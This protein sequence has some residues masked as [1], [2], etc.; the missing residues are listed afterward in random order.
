[1]ARARFVSGRRARLALALA[2]A[3]CAGAATVTGCVVNLGQ[4]AT[5]AAAGTGV[6][7]SAGAASGA[8][9][10]SG[11]G[12]A[13]GAGAG[14]ASDRFAGKASNL[15]SNATGLVSN[16]GAGLIGN[17]AAGFNGSVRGPLALIANG[18][19]LLDP[20]KGVFTDPGAGAF[21]TD[22]GAGVFFTDPGVGA[23]FTD[24]GVGAFFTEPGGAGQFAAQ[25]LGTL[26]PEP[27][28]LQ[29]LDQDY[30]RG[31][32]V[33]LTAP[34]ETLYR[35]G[36]HVIGT[37]TDAKGEYDLA[38]AR[39]AD[40]LPV[41]VNA[42]FGGNRRLVGFTVSRKGPNRVELDVGSTYALELLRSEAR[43]DGK[44]FGNFDLGRLPDLVDRARGA[45]AAG[46]LGVDLDRLVIGRQ[47]QLAGD[48]ATVLASRRTDLQAWNDLLGRQLA[49]M[50]TLAGTF[51]YGLNGPDPAPATAAPTFGASAVALAGTSAFIADQFS[52]QIAEVDA[53]GSLR[54][55][56]ARMQTDPTVAKPPPVP[57]S[58]ALTADVLV[59]SPIGL[60]ADEA[61]NLFV[62]MFSAVGAPRNQVLMICREPSPKF[63]LSGLEAGRIY[64]IAGSPEARSDLA[65]FNG[66][67]GLAIDDAGNLFVADMKNDRVVRVERDAGTLSVVAGKGP[68][69]LRSLSDAEKAAN[70]AHLFAP[71]AVAWRRT[72]EGEELFVVDTFFGRIRKV[73]ASGGNWVAAR[74]STLAGSGTAVSAKDSP[75]VPGGF[76]GDGGPALSARF[77]FAQV[78]TYD[79][80]GSEIPLGGLAVDP[81]RG[82]L[83]VA[84]T[85]NGRIR[86]IDLGSG[87][88]STLAGGGQN[89]R[90]G[91]ARDCRLA[92]PAGLAV[93][94]VGDLL[95]ADPGASVVRRVALPD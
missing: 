66:P 30:L 55:V 53:S 44:T 76:A 67:S 81:V 71:A 89:P 91:L 29:A 18:S 54:L 7:G 87:L 70:Q 38:A 59:P 12:T 64:R 74:M 24:P 61:G 14:G 82:R 9:G 57:E 39:L 68:G 6:L 48:Y 90:D 40:G 41:M 32:L 85:Y 58:G 27:R 93:T 21:F 63:G 26:Q 11:A 17:N 62:T 95:I 10:A 86:C 84:D 49:P 51:R 65:G 79:W 52:H 16:K 36:G 28:S 33:Y 37:T 3:G 56:T 43:R 83:Y 25:G 75:I 31:A 20:R 88:V 2:L 4:G 1:M 80:R 15:I 72:A 35:R 34:D 19:A 60:V 45:I 23:F 13:G 94:N 8:G 47:R 73:T 77:H 78:D 5:G 69:A 42:L 46:L 92:A 50:I 22:P